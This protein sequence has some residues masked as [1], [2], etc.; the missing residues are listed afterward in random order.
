LSYA[1]MVALLTKAILELKTT[2]D[3]Q[4]TEIAALKAKVGA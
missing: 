3:A 2:V 1:N 4:A